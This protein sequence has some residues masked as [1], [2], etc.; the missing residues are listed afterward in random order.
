MKPR[1]PRFAWLVPSVVLIALIALPGATPGSANARAGASA[2]P[3]AGC[4]VTLPNGVAVGGADA[5]PLLYGNESLSTVLWPEGIILMTPLDAAKPGGPY[6]MKFPWWRGAFGE[7]TITGRRLDGEAPPLTADI[8]SGY[9]K[10]GFQASGVWFPTPG[11]WEVTGHV[12]AASLTFVT[13]V[14]AVEEPPMGPVATPP[15][16]ASPMNACPVTFPNGNVPPGA[17]ATNQWHGGAPLWTMLWPTGEEPMSAGLVLPDGVFVSTWSWWRGEPGR[18]TVEARRLDA[19]APVLKAVA[20]EVYG[21]SGAQPAVLFFPTPGC[22]EVTGRLNETTL[23][24]V[25]KVVA[26]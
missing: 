8:S 15:T 21:D 17:P 3:A 23:T 18:L 6:G 16:S 9:G 24:V 14:V 11:C 26:P 7:L 12:G 25:E 10:H 5:S 20:P 1:S 22:W 13:L 2:T 19:P 4:P